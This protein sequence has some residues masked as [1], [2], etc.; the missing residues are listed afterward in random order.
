[1]ALSRVQVFLRP[2]YV[3]RLKERAAKAER[4]LSDYARIIIEAELDE[5]EK[6][7]R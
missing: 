3:A 5:P 4:S 6:G 2:S 1:M 7:E